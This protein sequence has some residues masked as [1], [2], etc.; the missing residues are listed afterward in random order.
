[1]AGFLYKKLYIRQFWVKVLE[2][3]KS[4]IRPQPTGFGLGSN[5][6]HDINRAALATNID[7]IAGVILWW[8]IPSPPTLKDSW[9][10][11]F[12]WSSV[13]GRETSGLSPSH[14]LTQCVHGD[15][16]ILCWP[17]VD[18]ERNANVFFMKCHKMRIINFLN[19]SLWPLVKFCP[20]IFFGR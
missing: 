9:G 13:D 3:F 15:P 5:P 4:H 11:G 7:Q 18:L 17:T 8:G 20:E 1:M 2:R 19:W 14:V 12:N 10:G 6:L 16:K